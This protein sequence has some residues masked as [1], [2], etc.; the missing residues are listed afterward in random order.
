M[1]YDCTTFKYAKLA[2]LNNTDTTMNE[3][4]QHS[5]RDQLEE[6]ASPIEVLVYC[7][8]FFLFLL[9][10]EIVPIIPGSTCPVAEFWYN[11]HS[12]HKMKLK[13]H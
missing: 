13:V 12:S 1:G 10:R 8:H 2:T 9:E 3:L 5:L 11:L 7:T 4:L 6:F